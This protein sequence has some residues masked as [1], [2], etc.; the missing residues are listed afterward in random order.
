MQGFLR[1]LHALVKKEFKQLLRDN[2]SMLVGVVVPICLIFLMGYG[3]NMDVKRVP[4]AVVM[5]DASPTV[6]DMLSFMKG[7]EY[8]APYY[9]LSMKEAVALMDGRTVDTIVRVPSNFT[10][11]LYQQRGELQVILY[12]VDAANANIMKGY[13]EGGVNAWLMQNQSEFLV[14]DGNGLGTVTVVSRMWFNDA[15]TSTWYFIPGLIVLVITISGVF[16]TSLVMAREWERGTLEALFVTPVKI[17][18]ILL[19]KMIPYFCVAMIGFALCVL[20]SQV[21]FDVPMHG[22]FLIIL[23][24]TMLY[25]FVALGLGLMISSLTKNQFLA[26]QTALLVSMMPTMM[27]SGF[28]FDL[29]SVP[30]VVRIVGYALPPTYYMQLLKTLF[31]AGNNWQLIFKNCTILALYA[32]LFVGIAFRVT[33]KRVG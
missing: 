28:L 21:M 33:Q 23:F 6:Q 22:S 30:L 3:I 1:R 16:L 20:A 32:V 14:G 31:L 11:S 17:L 26:S 13:I 2:S 18:E 8:F 9:P 29:R 10:E 5:E 24:S 19:S 12:G 4:T 27:L 25:L 7:S 15:N